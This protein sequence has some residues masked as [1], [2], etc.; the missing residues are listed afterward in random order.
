M[1]CA[2]QPVKKYELRETAMAYE[3]DEASAQKIADAIE[4]TKGCANEQQTNKTLDA[5]FGNK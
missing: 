3:P 2:A 5:H 1:F 4:A